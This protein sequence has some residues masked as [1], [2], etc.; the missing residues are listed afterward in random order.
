MLVVLEGTLITPLVTKQTKFIIAGCKAEL[1][2]GTIRRRYYSKIK[3]S[4]PM[5][6]Y[7]L[8][9]YL[10][11]IRLKF[12]CRNKAKALKKLHKL[13]K[14][15]QLGRLQSEGLGKI[16]WL[17]GCFENTN[18]NNFV[19]LVTKGVSNLPS[20]MTSIIKLVIINKCICRDV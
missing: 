13:I 2:N 9:C 14:I 17:G 8:I 6:P 15:E 5:F 7:S 19:C 1:K 10:G 20:K 4:L 12:T 11:I 16:H 18:V 3:T